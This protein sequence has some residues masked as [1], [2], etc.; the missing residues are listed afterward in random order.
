MSYSPFGLQ[1][2]LVEE[3]ISLYLKAALLSRKIFLLLAF[4]LY[5]SFVGLLSI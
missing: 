1:C 5:R 2:L 4:T 3:R